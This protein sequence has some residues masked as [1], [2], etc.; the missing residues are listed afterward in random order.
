VVDSAISDSLVGRLLD[1]RYRVESRIAR[2]GM[3]TVYTALDTRLERI[4]AVKVMHPVFADDDEFV[5]RFIREAKSAARLSHPNVVAVFDQGEDAGHVFLAMEYIQGRTLRDLIRE[6]GQLSSQEALSIMAP[7]LSALAAAHAAG[8]IHRDIKPENVL[9]ADDGRVKVADF[10]LARAMAGRQTTT[11]TLIGTVAYLAP[12]QITRGVADA[13]TDVYAAGIVLFEMVTGQPPYDGDT[14]IS[15]AYRHAHE[16]V[17]VPSSLV[18]GIPPAVDALIERATARNPDQRPG[19]AAAF[20]TLVQRV[21]RTLPALDADGDRPTVFTP[22]GHETLVVEL[23]DAAR[24]QGPAVPP[25]DLPP[26]LALADD[27][28]PRRRRRRRG[29]IAFLL[30][31]LLAAALGGAGWRYGKSDHAGK[32]GVAG[33]AGVG[34]AAATYE[35]VPSVVSTAGVAVTPAEASA[36]LT[37]VGLRMV[38]APASA[39]DP[40]YS[41]TVPIGDVLTQSPPANTGKLTKGSAVTITVSAGPQRTTVPSFDPAGTTTLSSYETALTQANLVPAPTPVEQY[42]AVPIGDVLGV[43]PAAGSV[44]N[45]NTPITITVSAG[46]APLPIPY[47]V[48]KSESAAKLLLSAAGLQITEKHDYSTKVAQGY[49]IAQDPDPYVNATA[50]DTITVDISKGPQLFPVPD[51]VTHNYVHP[52]T[53][54][55]ATNTLTNAGFTVKVSSEGFFHWVTSQSP[56]AGTLVPAGTQ[57]TITAH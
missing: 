44:Q 12:E 57:I 55:A 53:V 8:L 42:S 9:L 54:S 43:T 25:T 33:V 15:V 26:E 10:G 13:R 23:P 17:P 30:I 14:P 20:L 5:A 4:V 49:V 22:R 39:G 48:G 31:L 28:P 24:S 11:S 27:E 40:A 3:A 52:V 46:P 2:G 51:V 32:K 21:R 34:K 47:L 16:D 7:V 41:E 19:D 45:I 6:R 35:T 56:K 1:G 18:P 29:L 50:G 37:A 38:I 36:R